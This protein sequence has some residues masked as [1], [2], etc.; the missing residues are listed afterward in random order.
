MKDF[1]LKDLYIAYYDCRKNKRNTLNA[2]DFEQNLEEN[3]ISLYNELLN[4][5]YKI[6]TSICFISRYPKPR[7]IFAANFRDRIVHHLLY[8][9]IEKVFS[10]TFVYDSSASQVWKW[11]L[12]AQNRLYRHMQ[13]SSDNFKNKVYYLQ[14]DIKNFFPSISKDILEK[15]INKK[16][17]SSF[18]KKYILQI[19]WHNPTKDFVYR[20]DK[21]LYTKIK[22]YKSLFFVPK[23]K[24][25]PIWN[26]TSQF[27]ANI[28][29]N[30]LDNYIKRDLKCKYY[31]RYVDDF[32]ILSSDKNKLKYLRNK[33]KVF[34]KQ[35]LDLEVHPNKIIIQSI[36]QWI[37]YVWAVV[38]PYCR[39]TRNRTYWNLENILYK[40]KLK[41]D[42]EKN[43]NI[44]RSLSQLNSY[45]WFLK[46]T[47]YKN[48][49]VKII[50][51]YYKYINLY[52]YIDYDRM[53]F[54]VRE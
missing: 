52:F 44:D 8:N 30:E 3:I 34:T 49:F 50:N 14:M 25:L 6:W 11:I 23:N 22:K 9:K 21:K 1:S 12:F 28:Y 17:I 45:M 2:L 40:L 26:L 29:L 16:E 20:L 18:Y 43:I 53:H 47:N 31:Q 10:R 39:Y 51:K 13:S 32:I 41:I 37:N 46:H 4:W 5:T 36:D 27:F 42:N 33:I 54:V 15:L 19:L 7:E 35:K 48:K 38:K 24:W